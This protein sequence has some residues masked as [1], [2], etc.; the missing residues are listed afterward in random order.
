M[1][2]SHSRE[3]G[4]S[5]VD[6]KT[7]SCKTTFSMVGGGK[8]RRCYVCEKEVEMMGTVKEHM[9]KKHT[10]KQFKFS[11]S[12]ADVCK[13]AC[14]LCGKVMTLQRMRTHTKEK[15]GMGITDYKSN[16]N[17]NF[18]DLEEKVFHACGICKEPV[19]LDMD[20]LVGHLNN[21]KASHGGISQ[22]EYKAKFLLKTKSQRKKE[23]A[24]DFLLPNEADV[25]TF[26]GALSD[27]DTAALVEDLVEKEEEE[28]L[29]K[30]PGLPSTVPNLYQ[31]PQRKNSG[32]RQTDEPVGRLPGFG[33]FA[34][35]GYLDGGEHP[36][37]G[38]AILN[39]NLESELN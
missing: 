34:V 25:K 15:H 22:G 11:N 9:E 4:K 14:K 1:L 13:T 6:D 8:L 7:V 29:F 39:H 35:D 10:A 33:E 31:K 20:I 2:D 30:V 38:G 24:K 26:I 19:L 17:Q 32:Q 12:F 18:F 28:Q 23:P 21:S 36:Q 5:F 16:F 27:V 37:G 3:K